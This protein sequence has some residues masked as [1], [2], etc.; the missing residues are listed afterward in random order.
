MKIT[1]FLCKTIKM[2]VSVL[3]IINNLRKSICA[4]EIKH[5]CLSVN[6]KIVLD[7]FARK[8]LPREIHIFIK[9]NG[10]RKSALPKAIAGHPADKIQR[11][12]IVLYGES[13]MRKAPDQIAR[14]HFFGFSKSIELRGISLAKCIH[15]AVQSRFPKGTPLNGVDFEKSL[16]AETEIL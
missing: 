4:L 14:K 7:G 5:L 3:L 10:V 8:I 15:A 16:Y 2:I 12:E 1:H 11:G 6:D 9:R 13:I